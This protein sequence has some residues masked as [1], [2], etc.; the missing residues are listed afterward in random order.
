MNL[1]ECIDFA[2]E[3][4]VCYLATCDGDQP[5]VRAL[6]FWFADTT[7]FYFQTGMIKAFYKQLLENP[8][9]EVCF[10]S[11]GGTRMLRI[12]GSV[13]FVQDKA[14]KVKA[15][16]DRPFLK[17]FGLTA[18]SPGLI[19]FRIAHGKAHFWTM[20]SNLKPKEEIGF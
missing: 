7:G 3:N 10:Y 5:R 13:E 11:N 2:N 14:L 1:K 16:E 12:N 17:D 19:I 9:T 8:K 18:D 6:G 20:E 15:I 4:K